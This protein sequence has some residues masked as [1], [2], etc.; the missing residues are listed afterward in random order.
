MIPAS[1]Y[2]GGY[3]AY[4]LAWDR[5]YLWL[6]AKHPDQYSGV[7]FKIDLYGPGTPEITI[8]INS[9]NFGDVIVGDTTF[10]YLE[11]TNTGTADLTIDSASL[12]NPA[13]FILTQFPSQ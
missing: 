4:G 8:P 1:G 7:I 9:Y 10:L 5:Q 3:Y 11:C 6:I 12:S 2:S 13:F